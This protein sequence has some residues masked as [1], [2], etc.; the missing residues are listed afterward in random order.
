MI[1]KIN[2]NDGTITAICDVL[3]DLAEKLEEKEQMG[4]KAT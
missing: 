2:I 1:K 3:L 4:F